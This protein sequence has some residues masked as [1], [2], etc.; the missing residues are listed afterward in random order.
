MESTRFG[1]WVQSRCN[2][3]GRKTQEKKKLAKKKP[4]VEP[5]TGATS[6]R[7]NQ[8]GQSRFD[9]LLPAAAQEDQAYRLAEELQAALMD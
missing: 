2:T 3:P 8:I 6:A 4:I 5:A 9:H 1:R 7:G